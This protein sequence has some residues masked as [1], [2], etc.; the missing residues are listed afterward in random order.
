[1]EGTSLQG[2]KSL[3]KTNVRSEEGEKK[4][5]ERGFGAE[6]RQVAG[7]LFLGDSQGDGTAVVQKKA[8]NSA[9]LE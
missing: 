5:I 9:N 7:W 2:E 3:H 1:M 4:T 8:E 6:L